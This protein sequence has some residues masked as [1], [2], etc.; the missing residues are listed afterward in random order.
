MYGSS[1]NAQLQQ[2]SGIRHLY[3]NDVMEIT[4]GQ[5]WQNSSQNPL[6]LRGAECHCHVAV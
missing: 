5:P 4:N 1:R 3:L 2:A 6:F